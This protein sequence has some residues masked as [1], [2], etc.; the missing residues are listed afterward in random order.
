M[1]EDERLALA[2]YNGETGGMLR[3]NGSSATYPNS[4]SEAAQARSR[5]LDTIVDAGVQLTHWWAFHSDRRTFGND[6]DT[7]SVRTDD[8]TA[9]TFRAVCEANRALQDRYAVNPLAAENTAVLRFAGGTTPDTF[10]PDDTAA[11]DTTGSGETSAPDTTGSGET[12]APDTTD[13]GETS[14][15]DTG[16]TSAPDT[17]GTGETSV[18]SSSGTDEPT[19]PASSGLGDPTSSE[20]PVTGDGQS[21]GNTQTDDSSVFWIAALIAALIAGIAVGAVVLIRKKK[22]A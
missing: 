2:L 7:W 16:E 22:K 17:T 8:G 1:N 21:T 3:E 15:P 6:T 11:P 19:P 12:S 10:D 13:T 20:V 9:P 14:A 4:G 18:P 5:Y